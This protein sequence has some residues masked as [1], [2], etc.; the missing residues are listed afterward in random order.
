MCLALL[1]YGL[2]EPLSRDRPPV[3]ATVRYAPSMRRPI[4]Q[5]AGL[6]KASIVEAAVTLVNRA[7][8][9]ALTMSSVA[10]DLG[11]SQPA[12]YSHFS[13]LQG[14]QAAV[15]FAA[16]DVLEQRLLQAVEV[17]RG[18]RPLMALAEAYRAYVR[19]FPDLY[20][21]QMRGIRDSDPL[22]AAV[23]QAKAIEAGEVV[24]SALRTYGVD[25]ELVANVHVGLRAAI[26]GF[27][28]LEAQSALGWDADGDAAF[29]VF[30]ELVARGLTAITNRQSSAQATAAPGS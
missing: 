16:N 29:R 28:H 9:A 20:L 24:R 17:G 18:D 30:L 6:T 3:M 8:P 4:G 22:I 7:G 13:N 21:L 11:V 10:R 23:Q 15:T 5:H 14:L 25:E 1:S 2:S 12:L 19:E 26:H 27:A